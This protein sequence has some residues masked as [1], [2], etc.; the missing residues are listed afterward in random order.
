MI[1]SKLLN[2]DEIICS[3]VFLDELVAYRRDYNNKLQKVVTP[4]P[5]DHMLFVKL[6]E[7]DAGNTVESIVKGY[8]QNKWKMIENT[9]YSCA[10]HE[11]YQDPKRMLKY[12]LKR[13][14]GVVNKLVM[15]DG[16]ITDNPNEID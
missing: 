3:A 4:K 7:C 14:G 8:W 10:S 6:L 12:S 1:T 16:R 2:N 11:A 9:R 15:D 5:H 13:D